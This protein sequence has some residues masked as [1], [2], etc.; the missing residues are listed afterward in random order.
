M[1]TYSNARS[2]QTGTD[3]AVKY[4]MR[5]TRM[6]NRT[7]EKRRPAA[8]S[9]NTDSG[10]CDRQ[11]QLG[12]DCS[13]D[14]GVASR[15]AS[16]ERLTYKA[17]VSA[18]WAASYVEAATAETLASPGRAP[19]SSSDTVA[20][21]P[22]PALASPHMLSRRRFGYVP[23][24]DVSPP[25]Q[26]ASVGSTRRYAAMG[27]L[28]CSKDGQKPCTHQTGS[29][30]GCQIRWVLRAQSSSNAPTFRPVDSS[31]KTEPSPA[32]AS[33]PLQPANA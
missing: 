32:E 14:L 26:P 9:R 6:S 30:S 28:A 10:D 3:R 19:L 24:R 4:P 23:N 20:P 21:Q 2:R 31:G 17:I 1:P 16:S 11:R 7:A 33:G 27:A 22:L 13:T 18:S 5:A 8:P 12:D 25:R 15:T 29:S